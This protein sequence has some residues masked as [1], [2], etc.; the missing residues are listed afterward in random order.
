LDKVCAV[1]RA[2]AVLLAIVF[3]FL[4]TPYAAT[5]L[6]VL[7]A[8][9]ALNNGPEDSTRVYMITIVLFL[10]AKSVAV[11]PTAGATLAAIFTNLDMG[12]IG[13]SLVS[14]I[15]GLYARIRRDWAPGAT[16]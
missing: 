7:G 8:I 14:V 1:A 9:A 3:V 2:L 16:A 10:I 5:I 12:L 6:I 11:V 13:A 15:L 4:N